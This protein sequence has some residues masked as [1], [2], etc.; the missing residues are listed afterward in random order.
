MRPLDVRFSG[1][2]RVRA[3]DQPEIGIGGTCAWVLGALDQS[4]S[5]G[6][7]FEIANTS[8]EQLKDGRQAHLQLVTEYMDSMGRRIMR[9]TTLARTFA[10]I[11][12]D[13]GAPPRA[14]SVIHS[15]DSHPL[16]RRHG[17][18]PHGLRPGD[19]GRAHGAAGGLQGGE[20]GRQ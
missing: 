3:G 14:L 2:C 17:S 16:V 6:L 7:F 5:V 13:H 8:S 15:A 18:D 9:V 10:D 4:T 20:R 1:Q 11:R 19:R 12:T